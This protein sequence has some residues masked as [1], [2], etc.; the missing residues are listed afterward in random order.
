MSGILVD[1]G[2]TRQDRLVLQNLAA[3]VRDYRRRRRNEGQKQPGKA[4]RRDAATLATLKALND[5]AGAQ[6]DP[7]IFTST[8]LHNLQLPGILER[9]LFRPLVR[10]ARSVL[11]VET[12]VV[13]IVHL[14]LYFC[15]VHGHIYSHD[16]SAYT[17]WRYP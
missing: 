6:F 3:D 1:K 9:W 4:R 12:D 14:L 11:R 16:A 2:L 7:T 17:P 5:P 13:M 8:E 15:D 10:T